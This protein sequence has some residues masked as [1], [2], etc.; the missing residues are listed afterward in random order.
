MASS[1]TGPLLYTRLWLSTSLDTNF[2]VGKITS[3]FQSKLCTDNQCGYVILA[4]Q[5]GAVVPI[6]TG[7]SGLSIFQFQWIGKYSPSVFLR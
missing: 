6:A 1:S 7:A 2:I 5:A 3:V 4:P